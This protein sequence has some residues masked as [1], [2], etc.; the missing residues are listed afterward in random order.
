MPSEGG[1]FYKSTYHIIKAY[2]FLVLL[3]DLVLARFETEKNL[4]TK[5]KE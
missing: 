2:H 4:V 5:C 1:T 3:E